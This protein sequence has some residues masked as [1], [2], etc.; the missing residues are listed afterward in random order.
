MKKLISSLTA[1]CLVSSCAYLTHS[2]ENAYSAPEPTLRIASA[3]D[4]DLATVTRGYM[5]YQTQ[6]GQ[7]H[8]YK[9]AD[10]MSKAKWHQ[11]NWNAGLEKADEKDLLAYLVG[12]QRIRE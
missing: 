2:E 8:E 4:S 10:D 6:C 5:I 3:A 7:C 1:I 12:V 9:I 11:M